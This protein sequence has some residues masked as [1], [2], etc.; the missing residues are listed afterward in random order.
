MK[1]IC[2]EAA[3]YCEMYCFFYTK[4]PVLP[5]AKFSISCTIQEY[6]NYAATY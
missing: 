3:F 6:D 2:C 4:K 5:I 1:T